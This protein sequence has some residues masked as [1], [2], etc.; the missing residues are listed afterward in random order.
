MADLQVAL[1]ELKEDSDSGSLTA[2]AAPVSRRAP[3]W[4]W[5]VSGLAVVLLAVSVAAWLRLYRRA[6][7]DGISKVSA[8]AALS[9]Y[10]WGPAISPDGKQIAFVR[11]AEQEDNH[12]IFVQLVDEATPRRL[13]AD[14][15]FEYSPVWSPDSLRIA[16]LRD[17]PEGTEILMVPAAGGTERRLHLSKV[18]C[19][20]GIRVM[21]RQF[22]GVDWSPDGKSL[23]FVDRDSAQSP[24]SLFLLDIETRAVR[25][26][27]TPPAGLIGDGVSVFSPDGRWLA[28]AR[29]RYHYQSDIHVLPLTA[30]GE[31][32]GEARRLTGDNAMIAGLDWT[33]DG[34]G[35]VFSSA[36]GGVQ[37][38]WR[39]DLKEG[40]P[41]RLNVG[42]EN[43]YWPSVSRQGNRLAYTSSV[44][45]SNL[46]RISA[47]GAGG[48][49]EAPVKLTSSPLAD[50]Q[51]ALSADG[52]RLAWTSAQSGSWE[53]WSSESDGSRPFRLTKL[54]QYSMRPQ[55]APDGRQLAFLSPKGGV[56]H[57]YAVS[58]DGGSARRLTGGEF[59]EN[60]PSWS[61]DGQWIYFI[62]NRGDGMALWKAPSQGGPPQVVARKARRAPVESV[63][64]AW[65]YYDGPDGQIWRVASGGGEPSVVM[66]TGRRAVWNLSDSGICLLDPDAAGGPELRWVPFARGGRTEVRKLSGDAEDY[67]TGVNTIAISPDGRWVFYDHRDR[68]TGDIMLVENFR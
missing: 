26:L 17:T 41:Q 53:I 29:S 38:L 32:A 10:S 62:S 22:C 57:I 3:A 31:P 44:L 1:E 6:P 4:V 7:A 59:L 51:P 34:G 49:N 21:A 25:K 56:P 8:F 42:A 52:K 64:G 30:V 18:R 40:E 9:G 35:I 39:V 67:A 46:W 36:R 60:F 66:K 58:A 23:A 68:I 12:D 43:S 28:F 15:A 61:R 5:A 48:P 13:T 11:N 55:W 14:P 19:L 16:F 45:D 54:G 33:P 2:A 37:G 24:S 27:T 63:D 50:V 47:P 20:M 65:V